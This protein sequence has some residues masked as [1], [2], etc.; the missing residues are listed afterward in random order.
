MARANTLSCA[1][2]RLQFQDIGTRACGQIESS[3][4]HG[5]RCE[6]KERGDREVQYKKS[7]WWGGG[8]FSLSEIDSFNCISYIEEDRS[9]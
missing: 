9:Y 5:G 7:M 3:W 6:V 2:V 8:G 4:W 1:A